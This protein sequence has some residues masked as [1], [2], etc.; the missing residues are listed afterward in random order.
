M[1]TETNDKPPSRSGLAQDGMSIKNFQ[2]LSRRQTGSGDA[3][4]PVASASKDGAGSSSAS[5]SKPQS[6]K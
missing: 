2:E 3:K 4:Q 5:A 1:M 6:G